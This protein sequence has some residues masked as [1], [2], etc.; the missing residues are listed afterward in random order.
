[1]TKLNEAFE[2]KSEFAARVGVT[3]GRV[4]Q[5]VAAGL[6][7]REDGK[8]DIETGLAW[9]EANLDP[10]KRNKGGAKI[11]D[12][13]DGGPSLAEARRLHLIV[14]IQRAKIALRQERGELISADQAKITIFNRARAERD[15]HIAWVQR[16]APILAGELGCD[17]AQM[18]AALDR[19]MREH[20]EHLADT[21]LDVLKDA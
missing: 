6:P 11:E 4:S 14:Q 3:K 20:L 9:M 21:P 2:S 15:S 12:E 10:A 18:F 16:S 17:P 13:M 8:I 1:M 5:L 7:V 19:L